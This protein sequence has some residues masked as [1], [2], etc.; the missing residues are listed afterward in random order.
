MLSPLLFLLHYIFSGKL[1]HETM[2]TDD[3]GAGFAT[4][5]E[6]TICKK[7]ISRG[8]YLLK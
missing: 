1:N 7:E 2:K 4:A 6:S 8:N 3:I 5:Q